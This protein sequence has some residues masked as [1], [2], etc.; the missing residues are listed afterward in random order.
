MSHLLE[1]SFAFSDYFFERVFDEARDRRGVEATRLLSYRQVWRDITGN[2]DV[3]KLPY[4]D[5]YPHRPHDLHQIGEEAA[6]YWI[7]EASNMPG[8]F[9]ETVVTVSMTNP[10]EFEDRLWF[11]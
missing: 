9:L 10:N 5:S 11:A 6:G 3:V 8:S 7:L 1:C 2:M 4:L